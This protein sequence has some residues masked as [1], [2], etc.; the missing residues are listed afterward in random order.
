MD[1]IIIQLLAWYDAN[2]RDLPWRSTRNP[3]YIWIS[4][5]ILQQTRVAQGY[6]YFVR[7]VERFPTVEAL[8]EA[9]EDEVMRMW[10]GLG[11]YS[12]ARNLH[13]AARQVVAMG[14]F[15]ND[16]ES[17]R[18]L[19]GV[20]DYTAAAIASF[21]FDIP[22]AAVDGNVCRVWS[23]V[24]GIDEPID[25]ARGKQ[26]ITEAAQTLLPVNQAAKYNQAVMEFGALQCVPRNPDCANCPL[27]DKCVALSEGRVGQLPVK[28]H[29]T[30]VAPRYLTYLYIHTNEG[31]L[32]HKRTAEDI[33]KNLYELP[34]IE[35]AESSSV[36]DMLS[37]REFAFWHELIPSYIYKGSVEGVKHVL[38]HRILHV[39]FHELEVQGFMPCPEGFIFVP[40]GDLHRFALPRVIERYFLSHLHEDSHL[41]EH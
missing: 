41:L 15:P 6:D 40:Y 2:C 18:S 38:S 16:Y 11:Y 29:K 8:A 28:S 9:P 33:W 32:L 24:F 31:L 22:K 14:G 35:T 10:Q 3:Y 13:A 23:R 30:K 34:L 5:I 37:S 4:E 25:S 12:R 26:M 27:A 19:R 7:F 20:G 36:D 17:I 39:A 21:A 1:E